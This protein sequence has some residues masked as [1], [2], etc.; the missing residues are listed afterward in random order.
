MV[1]CFCLRHTEPERI[2]IDQP[3]WDQGTFYGRFRHFAF[4]TDPTTVLA[5]NAELLSS[6]VLVEQYR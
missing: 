4:T 5:S 2:N 3:L 6:K 1:Y